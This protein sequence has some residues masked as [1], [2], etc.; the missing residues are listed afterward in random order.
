M[1]ATLAWACCCALALLHRGSNRFEE[2]A[3]ELRIL[4]QVAPAYETL[5]TQAKCMSLGGL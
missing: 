5:T 4:L 1:M 3:I 2:I